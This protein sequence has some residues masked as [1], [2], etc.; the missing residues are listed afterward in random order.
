M[1]A[2]QV[3]SRLLGLYCAGLTLACTGADRE[4][5]RDSHFQG[6]F[7]LLEPKPGKRVVYGELA[8]LNPAKPVWDLAQWSSRFPLQPNNCFSSKDSLVYS[9]GAKR[10]VVGKLGSAAADLSLAVNAGTE[11]PEA[12]RSS[13]EP[14]VHHLRL[15]P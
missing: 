2:A 1:K 10:V 5:I 15:P 4:L 3:L 14:W 12:R 13:S 7:Y 9:N 8:G 11:Y 6:G